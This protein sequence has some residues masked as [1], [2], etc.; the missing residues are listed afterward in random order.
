MASD[1][2]R[3][4]KLEDDIKELKNQIKDLNGEMD[5]LD[6][7]AGSLSS[8]IGDS[9]NLL[10]DAL[11]SVSK[12]RK[13]F[14]QFALNTKDQY[15]YAEAL[16]KTSKDTAVTIGISV[17]RSQEFTKKKKIRLKKIRLS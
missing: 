13:E 11:L 14:T 8:K 5:R 10:G 7:T 12:I 3:L 17:G 2:E 4:K 1:E 15:K 16:A 9:K 6:N